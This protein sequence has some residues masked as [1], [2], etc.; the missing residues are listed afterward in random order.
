MGTFNVD[1]DSRYKVLPK[2]EYSVMVLKVEQKAPKQGE[3]DYLETSMEVIEG[4]FKGEIMVD[5]LSLSPKAA[6]RLAGFIHACG[7]VDPSQKGNQSFD[8]NDLLNKVLIVKGEPET[9]KGFEKFRP[10]SFKM[11]P[12]IARTSEAAP[13]EEAPAPAPAPAQAASKPAPALA[14]QRSSAPAN[15]RPI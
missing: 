4:E 2:G 13:A 9:F 12:D 14:P 8:T 11:H 7:M 10:T 3:F 5:R 6:P 15:R 1:P